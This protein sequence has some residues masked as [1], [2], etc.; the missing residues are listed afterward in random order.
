MV[1]SKIAASAAQQTAVLAATVQFL[2]AAPAT[3]QAALLLA[4]MVHSKV[5]E[6]AA[7]QAAVVASNLRQLGQ[8][9]LLHDRLLLSA[10][11]P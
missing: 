9:H 10:L 2:L 4:A 7:Q 1:Q 11:R 5:A 8:Q 6:P 3:Q